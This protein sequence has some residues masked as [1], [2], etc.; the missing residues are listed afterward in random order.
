[1][2]KDELTDSLCEWLSVFLD[3]KYSN[4]YLIEIVGYFYSHGFL[5]V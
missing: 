3:T 2:N 4:D 1:M 5:Q